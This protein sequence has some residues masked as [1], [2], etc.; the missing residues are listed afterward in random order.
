[1]NPS[2][3]NPRRGARATLKAILAAAI[4]CVTVSAAAQEIH[5]L[6]DTTGNVTFTDQPGLSPELQPAPDAETSRQPKR[7]AG[8]S[9]PRAAAAVDAKESARR[10]RQ[11]QSKRFEGIE[12]LPGEQTSGVPNNRYWQRQ[13]KLRRAVEQAQQRSNQTARQHIVQR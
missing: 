11:A 4:L 1:M 12:P 7:I 5:K 8:I 10:L 3:M 9:S 6:V 13:E 2:R